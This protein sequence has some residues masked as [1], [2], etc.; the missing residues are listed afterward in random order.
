MSRTNSKINP[1]TVIR[2]RQVGLDA[3]AQARARHAVA[4]DGASSAELGG[5][6]LEAGARPTGDLTAGRLWRA[7]GPQQRE[8]VEPHSEPGAS[9][10]G[11]WHRASTSSPGPGALSSLMG[12]AAHGPIVSL[13]PRR[14]RAVS[15]SETTS[16]STE[17]GRMLSGSTM[18][19][20]LAP[21]SVGP[22]PER[23]RGRVSEPCRDSDRPQ[24]GPKGGACRAE[25]RR[26]HRRL[27]R[28]AINVLPI[29]AG[30][31]ED[32]PPRQAASRGRRTLATATHGH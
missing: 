22:E 2:R 14:S 24:A 8:V 7:A 21:G 15:P 1:R 20:L 18:A 29:R 16:S 30:L 10:A 11:L 25:H 13:Q 19:G 32:G 17:M 5:V 26:H 6:A 12:H 31:A 3:A 27:L 9:T 28:L 23:Q 4:V